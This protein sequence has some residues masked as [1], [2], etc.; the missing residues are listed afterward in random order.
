MACVKDSVLYCGPGMR[1]R[2]AGP[3]TYLADRFTTVSRPALFAAVVAGAVALGELLTA[4]VSF[5]VIGEVRW[6]ALAIGFAAGLGT[7]A[8]AAAVL[9][10]LL[11][12][13]GEL[14]LSLEEAA[15]TDALTGLPNR[16][17]LF[18]SLGREIGRARRRAAGLAVIFVDIDTFKL[19]NDRHG[20]KVG[21]A[22]L[23]EAAAALRAGLRT[24][25]EVCRYGGDEF[26]M[27]LPDTG[28][29][30]GH[31]VAERVREAIA[32]ST[33]AGAIR[34]TISLGVAELAGSMDADALLKAADTAVYRAKLG[35]RNRSEVAPA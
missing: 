2:T 22:V 16:R 35:G 19:V 14:Q 27:V 30:D 8:A 28:A 18:E 24:Y 12:R 26:V 31:A 17:V 11:N 20:H 33:F 10:R 29:W 4:A 25:D 1:P 5:L 3:I 13:I 23:R 6:T 21:D 9:V 34:I 32:A 7:S 15:R